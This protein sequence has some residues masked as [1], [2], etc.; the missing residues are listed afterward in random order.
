MNDLKLLR[1]FFLHRSVDVSGVSGVGMVAMGVVFP[2]NSCVIRWLTDHK[3][4]V[5]WESLEAARV[6]HEHGGKTAFVFLDDAPTYP[7]VTWN[8]DML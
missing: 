1:R 8:E 7:L 2:D 3:S 6:V 5:V 4:T